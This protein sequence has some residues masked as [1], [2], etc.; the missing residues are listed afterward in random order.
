M[1][2]ARRVEKHHAKLTSSNT[3]NATETKSKA[4]LTSTWICSFSVEFVAVV[5]VHD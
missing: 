3:A 5:E 4:W 2:F 1:E